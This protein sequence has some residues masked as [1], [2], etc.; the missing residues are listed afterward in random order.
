LCC[1]VLCM[2]DIQPL[3]QPQLHTLPRAHSVPCTVC[4]MFNCFFGLDAYCMH[5]VQL[6]LWPRR[7]PHMESGCDSLIIHTKGIFSVYIEILFIV[8]SCCLRLQN[9]PL[10]MCLTEGEEAGWLLIAVA[11]AWILLCNLYLFIYLF[12]ILTSSVLIVG[13]EGYCSV[14]SRHTH[15]HTHTR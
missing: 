14:W 3:L 4:T 6:F 11:E 13:V 9:V 2:L 1:V 5:D 12:R 8:F 10:L 15:T 7:V